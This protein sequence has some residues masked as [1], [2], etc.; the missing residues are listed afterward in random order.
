MLNESYKTIQEVNGNLLGKNREIIMSKQRNFTVTAMTIN[1]INHLKPVCLY[2]SA[3][4]HQL[5]T[6]IQ[7][8]F[9]AI[10]DPALHS[11]KLLDQGIGTCMLCSV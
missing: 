10:L 7:N 3:I 9:R 8:V 5:G 2:E 4:G 6:E 1:R 11:V